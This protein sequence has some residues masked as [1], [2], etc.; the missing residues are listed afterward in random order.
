MS[1]VIFFLFLTG[2]G[3]V[4]HDEPTHPIMKEKCVDIAVDGCHFLCDGRWG[5]PLGEGFLIFREHSSC[6]KWVKENDQM[7]RSQ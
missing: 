2:C 4:A 6:R 3:D 7:A 5:T 1:R